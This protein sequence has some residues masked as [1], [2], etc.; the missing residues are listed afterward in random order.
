MI[1][2]KRLTLAASAAVLLCAASANAVTISILGGPNITGGPSNLSIT[3]S[4][5][6]ITL[7]DSHD[8]HSRTDWSIASATANASGGVDVTWDFGPY[9]A[10]DP[11]AA[12]GT[13]SF[14][15]LSDSGSTTPE[16]V[17]LDVFGT[18]FYRHRSNLGCCFPVAPRVTIDG[19]GLLHMYEPDN[20]SAW[21]NFSQSLSLMTNTR[22]FFSYSNTQYV[23]GTPQDSYM[24]TS[25]ATQ[26][27]YDVFVG[28][29]GTHGTISVDSLGFMNYNLSVR[30]SSVPEPGTLTLLGL[31]LVG[32]GLARRR[33]HA[34]ARA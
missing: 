18:G 22:Y 17:T 14:E 32:V 25:F 1:T 10:W 23:E 27:A 20:D 26:A 29:Y 13:L 9:G 5:S 34:Q 11:Y 19:P 21:D 12:F 2:M 4:G 31:A 28:T 3:T 16:A 30:P 7:S 33:A 15:I 24:P 8:L 6:L